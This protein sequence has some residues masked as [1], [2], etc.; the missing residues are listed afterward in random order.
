ML[1]RTKITAGIVLSLFLVTGGFVYSQNMQ[2][3]QQQ[4]VPDVSEDELEDFVY[5]Y[6]VVQEMQQELQKD[7]VAE[8]EEYDLTVQRFNSIIAAIQ[9]D[10][11]LYKEFQ[12]LLE[13]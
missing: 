4:E 6:E 3:Q 8:I 9:Q 2:T 5:A 7:M 13:N 1:T 12:E 10:S 11:E